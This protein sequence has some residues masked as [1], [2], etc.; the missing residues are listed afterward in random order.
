MA[1]LAEQYSGNPGENVTAQNTLHHSATYPSRITL[2]IVK[3]SDLPK[4]DNVKQQVLDMYPQLE[5]LF[6]TETGK[7]EE[8][9]LNVMKNILKGPPLM[10]T[11][12]PK[13]IETFSTYN[14]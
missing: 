10:D 9:Y 6:N 1:S 3:Q 2:P 4:V 13:N 7:V 14:K 8:K 12:I 5:K 11:L